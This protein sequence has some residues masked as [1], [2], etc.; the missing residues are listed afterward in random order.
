MLRVI[1]VIHLTTPAP[2]CLTNLVSVLYTRV[3]HA[4][5]ACLLPWPLVSMWSG[6]PYWLIWCLG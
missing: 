1:A 6:A 2:G 4:P 3:G 5:G